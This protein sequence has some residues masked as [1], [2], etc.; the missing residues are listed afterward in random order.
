MHIADYELGEEL[1][2]GNHGRTYR[3]VPPARLGTDAAAVAVKILDQRAGDEEFRRFADELRR[4]AGVRSPHLAR[5]LDAGRQNGTLWYATEYCPGGSLAAPAQPPAEA[6]VV[7]A[8]A[9][10]ARGAH[11]LHEAGVAHR[12]IKPANVMLT[13]SGGKLAD[14]GLSQVLSPGQTVFTGPGLVGSV[15]FMEPSVVRGEPPSRASDIWALGATLHRGLTGTSVFGEI[16]ADDLL[17][18]FR[19]VAST[20]PACDAAVP[21]RLRDIIELCLESEPADRPPTAA[22]LAGMLEEAVQ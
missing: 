5:V 1:G 3:A 9:G 16:P 7:R 11:A 22:A 12:D 6:A 21:G 19:H 15:E 13:S 20:D 8:V 17:A 2:R 10:A 14:L 4:C 18:A